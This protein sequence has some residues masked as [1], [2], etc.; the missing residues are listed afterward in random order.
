MK[1]FK[2]HFKK[3]NEFIYDHRKLKNVLETIITLIASLISAFCFAYG[4]RSFISTSITTYVDGKPIVQQ[5]NLISGGASGISQV[6]VRLCEVLFNNHDSFDTGLKN[7]LQSILYAAINVPLFLLAYFKLG[8]KFA[9]YTLINV[10]LVSILISIIPESWTD[11]FDIKDDFIARAIFAGLL[12]GLSSSIAIKFGH[13][14]GGIDIISLYISIKHHTSMGKYI[15]AINA[16]TITVFTLLQNNI[17]E[18][19]HMALYSIVYLF[20]SSR[21]IDAICTRNKKYQLQIITENADMDKILISNL[22]HSATVV[23]AKG[24]FKGTD[25]KMIYMNVSANEVKLAIKLVKEIDSKAFV[26][27]F[28]LHNLYGRFYI[29]PIE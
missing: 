2:N 10:L 28:S 18:Y 16:V 6:I 21:V 20:T 11:I 26:S 14:A 9:I 5:S 19:A 29:K 15:L 17:T 4:F 25:K 27:V 8:K 23:N 12:T 24:S 3:V 13:S 1:F 22:P 7:N